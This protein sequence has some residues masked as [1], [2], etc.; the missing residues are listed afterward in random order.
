[1]N[2]ILK[3]MKAIEQYF[4][5]FLNLWIKSESVTMETMTMKANKLVIL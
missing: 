2:E 5:Q 1:M 3:N 4:T